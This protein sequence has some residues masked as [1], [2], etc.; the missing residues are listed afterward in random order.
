MGCR[1]DVNDLLESSNWAYQSKQDERIRLSKARL[2]IDLLTLF[3]RKSR[4][5]A[6][7][8]H[9]IRFRVPDKTFWNW[10]VYGLGSTLRKV[11][12]IGWSRQL[13]A[14]SDHGVNL[15]TEPGEADIKLQTDLYL[16]WSSWRAQM[17]FPD[18]R[19]VVRVQHPWVPYRKIRRYH[20]SPKARGTIVFVP[21]SVPG[22]RY[23]EFNLDLFLDNLE[24]LPAELRPLTLCLQFHD[25]SAESALKITKA[26]HRC[27]TVGNSLSP[28]YADR[29]Y[30]LIRNF[31]YATSPSIGS[32]LFYCHELGNKYFL[33]DPESRFQRRLEPTPGVPLP[34]LAIVQ[35][36]EEAFAFKNLGQNSMAKNS[37]VAEGL[38]LDLGAEG[39]YGYEPFLELLK[40]RA[41]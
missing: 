16:T 6:G 23:E 22:L 11:L 41:R 20:L 15:G 19:V 31:E 38:G 25:A 26:G 7:I 2:A 1:A 36:I 33:F 4:L 29:F 28:S 37:V 12:G 30:A 35:K 13:N 21:H 34:N 40:K 9:L 14:G 8:E 27:V 32:Q 18:N 17:S 39:L 10:E 3:V 5:L 24:L